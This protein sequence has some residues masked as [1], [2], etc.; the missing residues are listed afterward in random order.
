MTRAYRRR[1][2]ELQPSLTVTGAK[3]RQPDLDRL[4]AVGSGLH[5][6]SGPELTSGVQLAVDDDVE[7]ADLGVIGRKLEGER[8]GVGADD[9][10]DTRRHPRLGDE[11]RSVDRRDAVRS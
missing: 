9:S 6:P 8:S 10:P 2:G 1:T 7:R 5:R 3:L 11:P 4:V